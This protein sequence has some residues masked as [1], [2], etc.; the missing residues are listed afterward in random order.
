[1]PVEVGTVIA[2]GVISDSEFVPEAMSYWRYIEQPGGATMVSLA[3]VGNGAP[4]VI[5]APPKAAMTDVVELMREQGG[6][7][8][9]ALFGEKRE[10]DP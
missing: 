6:A 1:M 4:V 7:T 8:A 5:T 10:A 2:V 9:D 3:P